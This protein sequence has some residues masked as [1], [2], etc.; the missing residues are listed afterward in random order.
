VNLD[1][2]LAPFEKRL[3]IRVFLG[4]TRLFRVRAI[5]R[6]ALRRVRNAPTDE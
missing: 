3:E 5:Q 1:S 4:E 2:A 6:T